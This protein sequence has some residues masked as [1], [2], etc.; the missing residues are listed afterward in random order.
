MTRIDLK[1]PAQAR[2]AH[3]RINRVSG[4][5]IAQR[6]DNGA[7]KE[8]LTPTHLDEQR[9]THPWIGSLSC[10]RAN[11]GGPYK[12]AFLTFQSVQE[13]GNHTRRWMVLVIPVRDS[14]EPIVGVSD[15]LPHELGRPAVVE[16]NQQHERPKSHELI[17]V[18][19]DRPN[20]RGNDSLGRG[21][22]ERARG[23]HPHREV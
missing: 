4:T 12:L 13:R 10:Q 23:F 6:L 20:E 16:S 3:E 21:P 1:R 7:S 8:V 22:P 9:F 18:A 2:D 15:S 11:Q 14:A 19:F 17:F 5:V